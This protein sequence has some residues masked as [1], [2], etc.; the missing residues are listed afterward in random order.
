MSR[1]N[2]APLLL[3]LLLLVVC[4]PALAQNGRNTASACPSEARESTDDIPD[5]DPERARTTA[6]RAKYTAWPAAA[7]PAES[8]KPS[9]S[10]SGG[11]SSDSENDV[12]RGLNS[13]W[14]S[15]LPG[16]FR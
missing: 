13:R 5:Q 7:K 14:H 15:F 3:G 2:H 11:G 16:M 9:Q 4:M 8:N 12:P 1:L 10:S 6:L